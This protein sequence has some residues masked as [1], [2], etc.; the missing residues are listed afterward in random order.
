MAKQIEYEEDENLPQDP[1]ENDGLDFEDKDTGLGEPVINGAQKVAKLVQATSKN[2]TIKKDK[3]KG[4]SS[5]K[6]ETNETIAEETAEQ[7]SEQTI[8][9]I[10]NQIVISIEDLN[11]RVTKIESDLYR[12]R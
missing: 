10:I 4:K 1:L 12:Q 2:E 9:Q 5:D 6:T 11:A 7:S 8:G 3:S